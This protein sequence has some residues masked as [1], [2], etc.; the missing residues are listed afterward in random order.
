[1]SLAVSAPPETR[2]MSAPSTR[3]APPTGVDADERGR[4]ARRVESASARVSDCGAGVVSSLPLLRAR[5]NARAAKATHR[6]D[7]ER[8]DPPTH[9]AK[10]RPSPPGMQ[11]L[12]SRL[13]G[14]IAQLVEHTTENRG[15]PGSSP[16]LAIAQKPCN[17]A[18]FSSAAGGSWTRSST[19]A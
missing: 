15:V 5:T 11:A 13:H 2:E 16:G 18:G 12:P 1:M 4:R 14:E 3:L 6:D 9:A 19:W 10:G 17:G 8:C 7:H